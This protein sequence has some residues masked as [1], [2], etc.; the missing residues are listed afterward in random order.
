[1]DKNDVADVVG[2]GKLILRCTL[3]SPFSRKI[4]FAVI[5]LGLSER[6]EIQ[7]CKPSNPNDTLRI[8]NPLG[9]MP[10]LVLPDGTAVYDSPVIME[11]LQDLKGKNQ[12]IPAGGM[13]RIRALT[14]IALADGIMD[15]GLAISNE[16]R[17]RTPEKH[18]EKWLQYQ[19]EKML[20][21]LAAF[22]R[23]LPDP[24]KTDAVSIG[25][26]VTLDYV[27]WRK[28]VEWRS[29]MPKLVAWF[30]KFGALEPAFHQTGRPPGY[31]NA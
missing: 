30:D 13:A 7:N 8:Q 22:E 21:G 1:M 17:W 25:L 24:A 4:R 11:F 6:V 20:R 12:L 3:G 14:R 18:E 26:A 31:G 15:A 10:T 19:R 27:D 9:K 28:H 16:S 2:P 5:A 29:T 23:D